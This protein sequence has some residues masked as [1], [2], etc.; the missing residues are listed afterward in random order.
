MAPTRLTR[1]QLLAQAVAAALCKQ[2]NCT[3]RELYEKHLQEL[4]G[5]AEN[6]G[7]N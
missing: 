4:M 1:R 2:H 7:I 3:P 6:P 5:L